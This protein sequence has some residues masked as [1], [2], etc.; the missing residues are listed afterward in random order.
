MTCIIGVFCN[1]C[2]KLVTTDEVNKNFGIIRADLKNKGWHHDRL[3][4]RDYCCDACR[5]AGANKPSEV[6]H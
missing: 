1:A 6:V 5:L 2:R 4:N 3:L